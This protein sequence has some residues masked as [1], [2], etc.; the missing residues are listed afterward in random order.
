M[1]KP[2][3]PSD[4]TPATALERALDQNVTVKDTVQR[5]SDE[6]AVINAVLNVELPG[7]VKKGDVAQALQKTDEL[8]IKIQDTAHEL[9]EVNEVLAQEIDARVD[10]ETEVATIKAALAREKA[11]RL[12]AEIRKP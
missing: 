11:K 4:A 6:L 9:A 5:S 3:P 10:L 12:K 2:L 7:D 1:S 8:E